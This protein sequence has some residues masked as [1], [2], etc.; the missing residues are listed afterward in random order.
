MF[1]AL[2]VRRQAM[3][4]TILKNL[5]RLKELKSEKQSMEQVLER[6]SDLYHQ[7]MM[8]R[9]QMTETWSTAV[10]SLNARNSTIH[11]LMEVNAN[12]SENCNIRFLSMLPKLNF[13]NQLNL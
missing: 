12:V 2:E 10:Q 5:S 6:T 3:Q 13:K 1:Q 7:S 4:R 8:E 9:R 11:E